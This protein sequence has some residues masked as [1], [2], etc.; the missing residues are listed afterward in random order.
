MSYLPTMKRVINGLFLLVLCLPF[1]AV[2]FSPQLRKSVQ[3]VVANPAEWDHARDAL[4]RTTPLW[5]KAVEM[6]SQVLY[7]LGTTS[8]T[9]IGVV[10]THGWVFLGDS[11]DHNLS[12]ALGRRVYSAAEVRRWSETLKLEQEWL[13]RRGIPL[14]FIVAPAKWAIYPD[15]LPVWAQHRIGVHSFDLLLQSPLHLPLVD[16]RP[17]LR[18]ARRTADT[19][20][21]LNSHWTDY[22]AWVAW[23]Q[24]AARLGSVDS[25]FTDLYIP[26]ANGAAANEYGS[27]FASMISLPERNHWTLPRLEQPLPS[28]EIVAP[29]GSITTVPG[30]TDTGLLDL[31]RTTR[32]PSVKNDIRALVLRD[33]M[34]DSLSPYLQSAF[35]ETVQVNHSLNVPDLA[36]NV[37]ALVENTKPDVVLYV[38]AERYLDRVPGGLALWRSANDFDLSA[39]WP[40]GEWKP[41]DPA[42]QGVRV[43]GVPSLDTQISLYWPEDARAHVV[44]I[45]LDAKWSGQLQIQLYAGGKPMVLGEQYVVGN[46]LLYFDLPPN[47]DGSRVTVVRGAGSAA[48]SLRG[49]TVRARELTSWNRN[50]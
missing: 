10:G 19:Y 31:P 18:E 24:I 32:T 26:A 4:R 22:G 33:S 29:G 23:K 35:S 7:E 50:P 3:S 11:F 39:S 34:G 21:P 44:R 37:P 48:A 46:N 20:S 1:V 28:Y 5:N 8:N 45:D 17:V 25:R 41:G 43:E 30:S 12:Q 9:D 14:L 38:M 6:Y 36:P 47:V 49:V 13:N 40:V 15:R 42:T 2:L 16:L 27:E